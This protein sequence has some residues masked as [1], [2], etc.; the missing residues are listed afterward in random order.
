LSVPTKGKQL[1]Y[2][3]GWVLSVDCGV[4]NHLVA[5]HLKGHFFTG[6]LSEEE[7]NLVIYMSK[8]LFD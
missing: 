1:S 5:E 8:T 4:R 2:E 6:R 3:E 7:E